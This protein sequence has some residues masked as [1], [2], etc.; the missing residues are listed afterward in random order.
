MLR[1]IIVP[2]PPRRARAAGLVLAGIL[3]VAGSLGLAACGSSGEHRRSVTATAAAASPAP[4]ASAGTPH[5]HAVRAFWVANAPNSDPVAVTPP[6]PGAMWVRFHSAA[7]GRTADYL[8]SLPTGYR[9]TR[10]YPVL[11]LLHGMPG[12]PMAFIA[13][14]HIVSRAEA[15]VR[16]GAMPPMILV[17]P[18]GRVNGNTQSDSEWANTQTGRYES[19][20]IDVVR[21]VDRRFS[22][23][24]DRRGRVIAGVSAG[25]YGAL[26]IALHHL[27]VFG[28][29]QVWS[30]YF[31]QTRIGVFADAS[32]AQLEDNSPLD[33]VARLAHALHRHRLGVFLY[34]GRFDQDSV[35]IPQMA[36]ELRAAGAT[37][38]DAIVR[39]GHNWTPWRRHL[40]QMLMLAGRDVGG[41]S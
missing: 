15:L 9:P 31:L 40:T 37:V 6:T 19:Y 17:Y 35:Q 5:R 3:G 25:A 21:D 29:A 41:A 36:A 34:S 22:T 1:S 27:A 16:R 14:A 24:A 7:L 13:N 12:R 10:S 32:R 18:D 33:Y 8:V 28:S 20:V 30:G 4:A 26:N 39:G 2:P 38:G 23:I 11:Y